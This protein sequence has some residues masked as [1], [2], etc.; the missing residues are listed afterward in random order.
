M[1]PTIDVTA[2]Q[3]KLILDLLDKYLPNV[4]VWVYGSRVKGTTRAHSDLDMVVFT[5]QGQKTGVADLKEAFEESN[6]P[7]RVDLFC[8]DEVPERFRETIQK[9][10]V[11]LVG[12]QSQLAQN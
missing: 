7:F 9:E 11:I 2:D 10:H 6:L 3:R 4:M 1:I 12:A 8:W 5:S